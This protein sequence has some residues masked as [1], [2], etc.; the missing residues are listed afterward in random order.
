MNEAGT[1]GQGCPQKQWMLAFPSTDPIHRRLGRL[2]VFALVALFIPKPG[3]AQE[4]VGSPLAQALLRE[5]ARLESLLEQD[6][7]REARHQADLVWARDVLDRAA[8]AGNTA[9]R[10]KAQQAVVAA[11]G[12]LTR[13]RAVTRFHQEWLAKV[14]RALTW[15]DRSDGAGVVIDLRGAV[16]RL[17]QADWQTYD[18]QTPLQPGESIRTSEDGLVR[19][20]LSDGGDLTLGGSSELVVRHMGR[21]SSV[22]EAIKG[23]LHAVSC[24]LA[25]D[26]SR[27]CR[28]WGIRVRG[29]TGSVRGT[30]FELELT[31]QG[32]AVLTVLEGDVELRND[33]TKEVVHV[34]TG[35]RL[36]FTPG[37]RLA[38]P[39]SIN[40]RDLV[41]WWEQVP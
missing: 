26:D 28:K 31:S 33:S 35:Q 23:R 22:Y 30:E 29:Y 16:Q 15:A 32:P 27:G 12:A 34:T 10:Q 36:L 9:A 4:S 24:R 13:S 38:K 3:N 8:R 20:L 18:G 40:P 1:Y 2:A 25:G 17:S 21:D 37:E 11:D 14:D 5:R 6:R 41:R 39:D 7:Q 19:V